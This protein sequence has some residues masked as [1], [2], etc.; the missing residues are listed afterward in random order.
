MSYAGR[1]PRSRR[2]LASAAVATSASSRAR[3]AGRH[4]LERELPIT[5]RGIARSRTARPVADHHEL[6]W[7]HIAIFASGALLFAPQSGSRTRH[8]IARQGRQLRERTT[9]A[10]EDLRHE[11]RHAAQRGRRKLTRRFRDRRARRELHDDALMDD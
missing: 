6:D 5:S 3:D 7:Q 8:D 11:L 2:G 9:D 10:W 1:D 4:V